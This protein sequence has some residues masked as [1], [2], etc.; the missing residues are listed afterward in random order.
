LS[1]MRRHH[2]RIDVRDRGKGFTPPN[3]HRR[4]RSRARGARPRLNDKGPDRFS[5]STHA[6]SSRSPTCACSLPR[7]RLRA[8]RDA[9]RLELFR[10]GR[11]SGTPSAKFGSMSASEIPWGSVTLRENVRHT[12]TG[13]SDP[14]RPRPRAHAGAADSQD[15]VV[16]LDR[17][18]VLLHAGTIHGD[19]DLALL[20]HVHGGI[21]ELLPCGRVV[22]SASTHPRRFPCRRACP[23]A[24]CETPPHRGAS[25]NRAEAALLRGR[26]GPS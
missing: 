20:P 25:R 12:R 1:P 15:S 21:H 7:W 16:D 3:N 8:D 9:P 11:T 4:P 19:N 24:G 26:P 18:L 5:P 13:S 2:A 23:R 6:R 14:P 22:P 10:L 17:D